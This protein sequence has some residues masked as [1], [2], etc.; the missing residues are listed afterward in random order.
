MLP[1]SWYWTWWMEG[2]A[3]SCWF[4]D[5]T[6][7][8]LLVAVTESDD[9]FFFAK[10]FDVISIELTCFG[11]KCSLLLTWDYSSNVVEITLTKILHMNKKKKKAGTFI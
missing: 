4:F 9:F 2:V 5:N 7:L 10:L 3:F 6:T 11:K 1:V 8:E